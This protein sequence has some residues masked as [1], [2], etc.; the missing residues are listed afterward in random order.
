M[1]EFINP[2]KFEELQQRFASC[3]KAGPKKVCC[4]SKYVQVDIST[5]TLN[6]RQEISP[7][8]QQELTS[9]K[10]YKLF[11]QIDCGKAASAI[12][13]GNGEN[14][15]LLS[16]PWAVRLGYRDPSDGFISYNCGGTLITPYYVLTAAH[17]I[18]LRRTKLVL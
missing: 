16:H 4:E 14:A 8:S 5:S 9:H 12:R 18:E 2:D 7:T 6:P 13:I 15:G 3:M 10:N 17:C 1:T 11:D